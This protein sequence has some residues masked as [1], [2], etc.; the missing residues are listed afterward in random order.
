MR[1]PAV[2]LL[3]AASLAVAVLTSCSTEDETRGSAEPTSAASAAATAGSDETPSETPSG[4]TDMAITTTVEPLVLSSSTVNADSC[5]L[6]PGDPVDQSWYEVT[7][8]AH[9]DLES[10]SF[11]LVDPVGVRQVGQAVS[12]PPVNFGGRIDY[13]GAS[14]WQDRA[15]GYDSVFT[16][17][18]AAERVDFLSPLEGQTGLVAFHLRFDPDVVASR[19]GASVAGVKARYRLQDGTG[20]EAVVDVPSRWRSGSC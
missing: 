9:A 7:W 18:R 19:Q 16:D 10:F 17:A 1:L 4:G 3:A 8:K 13:S 12:V 20:G 15:E 2:P 14:T 5:L 6:D 11:E